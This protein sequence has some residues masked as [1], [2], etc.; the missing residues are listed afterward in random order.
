LYRATEAKRLGQAI[1]DFGTYLKLPRLLHQ[2]SF[3]KNLLLALRDQLKRG[4]HLRPLGDYPRASLMRALPCLLG[5]TQAGVAEA[6]KFLPS[7]DGAA[8]QPESWEAVYSKWWAN[9]A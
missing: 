9:Y 2:N 5:L 8:T 7:C 1:P 3:S 6:G 4:A